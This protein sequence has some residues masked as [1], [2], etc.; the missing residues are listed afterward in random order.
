MK[1]GRT[2]QLFMATT[3]VATVVVGCAP[4]SEQSPPASSNASPATATDEGGEGGEGGQGGQTTGDTAVDLM[5]NLGLMKG[6]L[7]V[8]Q[9][10]IAKKQYKEATPHIGHPAE[11]IYGDIEAELTQRQIPQFKDML[12][13]M[14]DLIK[15]A[16]DS[17]ELQKS[18]DASMQSI[19]AAIAALPVAKRQ[20]PEFVMQVISGLLGTAADEYK[21]AIA[22]GKFVELVEYQDSPWIF[23][24]C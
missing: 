2:I 7:M 18:Y 3:M 12:N 9:E 20:S 14:S 19:D 17:P 24:L 1:Y 21:A 13:K 10:L 16:P 15:S 6:H 8:A 5:T 22:D 11:E 23:T 4:Q